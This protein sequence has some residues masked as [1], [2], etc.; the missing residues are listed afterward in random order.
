MTAT[1][2]RPCVGR[3]GAVQSEHRDIK[4]SDCGLY[5]IEDMRPINELRMR[6]RMRARW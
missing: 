4:P 3:S 1:E 6:M 2:P 5:G